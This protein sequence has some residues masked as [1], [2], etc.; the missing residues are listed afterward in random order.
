MTRKISIRVLRSGR[1]RFIVSTPRF[2]FLALSI[3]DA[4]DTL[5]HNPHLWREP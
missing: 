4:L 2:Q 3:S 1:W 5:V